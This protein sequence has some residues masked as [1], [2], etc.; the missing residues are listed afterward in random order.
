MALRKCI[1]SVISSSPVLPAPCDLIVKVFGRV[2]IISVIKSGRESTVSVCVFHVLREC[3]VFKTP[4]F[5]VSP[6]PP[7]KLFS[8]F[9]FFHSQD[10]AWSRPTFLFLHT[11]F[12]GPLSSMEWSTTKVSVAK[13]SGT[14]VFKVSLF[15][16]TMFWS[17]SVK[18]W[19][20]LHPSGRRRTRLP[21]WNSSS[22]HVSA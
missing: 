12:V 9:V 19:V 17:N 21:L 1:L 20:L 7:I 16:L 4:C 15:G 22:L 3:T 18:C 5:V 11:Y 14:P 13:H 2:V 10:P 6:T 8:P